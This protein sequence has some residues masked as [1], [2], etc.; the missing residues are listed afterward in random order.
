[1]WDGTVEH[2][3]GAKHFIMFDAPVWMYA[4]IDTFHDGK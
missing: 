3:K 1:V 2:F 4:Q